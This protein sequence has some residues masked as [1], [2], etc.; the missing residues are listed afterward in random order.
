MLVIRYGTK[1]L[2]ATYFLEDKTDQFKETGN[3]RMKRDLGI[4]V[5]KD[6]KWREQVNHSVNKANRK[7]GLLKRTFESRNSIL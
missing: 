1:N 6:M 5:T 4:M 3:S 2:K 7:L